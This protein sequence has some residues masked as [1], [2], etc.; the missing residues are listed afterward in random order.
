MMHNVLGGNPRTDRISIWMRFT[1][2]GQ[3]MHTP[4][5][6]DM[7][8]ENGLGMVKH[9]FQSLLELFVKR[10]TYSYEIDSRRSLENVG[11]IGKGAVMVYMGQTLT[12]GDDR[13]EGPIIEFIPE[14][15][16]SSEDAN[17]N[18]SG[19]DSWPDPVTKEVEEEEE[20][21]FPLP[22]MGVLPFEENDEPYP[23]PWIGV[24]NMDAIY[25]NIMGSNLLRP[26]RSAWLR[27]PLTEGLGGSHLCPC[28]PLPL[29]EGGGAKRSALGVAN[30]SP[31]IMVP[32][33]DDDNVLLP[34]GVGVGQ[35]F[36]TKDALQM[37]LKDYCIS[38]HVQ[39]KLVLGD[40]PLL[41]D[42]DSHRSEAIWRGEDPGCL[43]CTEH[44][45]TL[46]QWPVDE[47]ILSYI[48][49]A[50]F[51]ALY[52]VQWLRLDKSLITA[53]VERWSETN[54]FH[55]ANGEMTVTLEDVAVLLRLRVDGD[56]VTGLTRGDWMELARVFLGVELSPG[57]FWGGRL[58]LSWIKGR[59]L[60]CLDD[61][62]EEVI[63]QHV[64]AY[65]LHLVGA[66]IFSDGS[67]RGVHM[68]YLALFEDFEA[69]ERYS[70]GA[71]T[72]SFLY[73]D[74]AKACLTLMQINSSFKNFST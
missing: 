72:L 26:G 41:Y 50:G 73:R 62:P 66:T 74:L 5:L 27:P 12:E 21:E 48:E 52:R 38:R 65:L 56:A 24:M 45:Q 6:D 30:L 31:N 18:S 40:T 9:G 23:D 49:V 47:R 32:G 42:Q 64:R 51:S 33:V 58:S 60:F 35:K 29:L 22:I 57:S 25:T 2:N 71:A 28:G 7:S 61:A 69:A 17:D 70:W 37:Y 14:E 15:R 55:L 34:V 3:L 11:G 63:Q 10:D 20:V 46:R 43:E 59:F 1:S 8:L 36:M 13:V 16:E 67:A 68:A 19:E 39:F 4:V 53:L 54:T 44:F